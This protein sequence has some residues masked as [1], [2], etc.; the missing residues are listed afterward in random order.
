MYEFLPIDFSL[1]YGLF[2]LIKQRIENILGWNE[3]KQ[4]YV[5][6]NKPT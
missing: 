3:E 2:F 1:L 6:E 4:I 5:E